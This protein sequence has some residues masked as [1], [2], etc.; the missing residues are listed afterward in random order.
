MDFKNLK[1]IDIKNI[2]DKK[3]K[4]NNIDTEHDKSASTKEGSKNVFIYSLAIAGGVVIVSVVISVLS[5][6]RYDPSLSGVVDTSRVDAI[7]TF[8]QSESTDKYQTMIDKHTDEDKN[9]ELDIKTVFSS[10]GRDYP[11]TPILNKGTDTS[12]TK[13]CKFIYTELKPAI[14]SY[15]EANDNK[16]PI[17]KMENSSKLEVDLNLL[18]DLINIKDI[19]LNGYT[20][21]L[22][23]NADSANIKISVYK[24]NE[25]VPVTLFDPTLFTIDEL[26][27]NQVSITQGKHTLILKPMEEYNNIRLQKIDVSSGSITLVDTITKKTVRINQR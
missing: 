11:F 1:D 14:I 22:N 27:K 24:D 19:G 16:L 13:L 26:N 8:I 3:N 18:K 9:A 7:K 2:F 6:N 4:K 5:I 20:Y 15:K 23:D 12:S 21:V 25:L 10:T 17:K